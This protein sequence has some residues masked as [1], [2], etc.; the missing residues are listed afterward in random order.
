MAENDTRPVNLDLFKF[1]WPVTAMASIAHRICAVISWVGLGITLY[2]LRIISQSATQFDQ[3]LGLL[4]TSFLVQF[5]AWGLLSAFGY[6]CIGTI[7]H[8]SQDMG[9]FEELDS[10]RMVSWLSLILGVALSI[11]IGVFVWA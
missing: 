11:L 9:Y 6:Y 10:G 2:T 3:F 8:V 4:Q 7:K 5:V 1:S